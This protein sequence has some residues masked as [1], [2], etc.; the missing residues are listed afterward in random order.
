MSI[1]S[2]DR[3]SSRPTREGRPCRVTSPSTRVVVVSWEVASL[4][5]VDGKTLIGMGT[6][7]SKSSLTGYGVAFLLEMPFP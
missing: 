2:R 4:L 3:V 5:Y 1:S 6:K 7:P